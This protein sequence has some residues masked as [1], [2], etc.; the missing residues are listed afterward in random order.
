ME[1]AM[2]NWTIAP[3]ANAC[4]QEVEHRTDGPS[5]SRGPTFRTSGSVVKRANNV[6]TVKQQE[7]VRLQAA[8]RHQHWARNEIRR[9]EKCE[10]KAEQRMLATQRQF[11]GAARWV[12]IFGCE[13]IE[14]LNWAEA[15]V[16]AA[17]K[18]DDAADQRL[19]LI[20]RLKA[21]RRCLADA[22][23]AIDEVRHD[24]GPTVSILHR[25]TGKLP[26]QQRRAC[27]C[28]A[29]TQSSKCSNK[30]VGATRQA[31]LAPNQNEGERK[32]NV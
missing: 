4:A 18:W 14:A 5:G 25:E 10:R 28:C 3:V 2:S 30:P 13:P 27:R 11:E 23:R 15:L 22:E 17:R 7:I 1:R 12:H 8:I 16:R 20:N 21:A 32:W 9:I 6:E 19:E 26:H 31:R 24:I 29:T